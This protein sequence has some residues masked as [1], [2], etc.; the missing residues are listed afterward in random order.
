M[1]Q[2]I[3]KSTL[4]MDLIWERIGTGMELM[5]IH[6]ERKSVVDYIGIQ[7]GMEYCVMW[8]NEIRTMKSKIFKYVS[9]V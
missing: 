2:S 3:Q 4:E 5:G 7:I 1:K 6:Q 9:Y 8:E